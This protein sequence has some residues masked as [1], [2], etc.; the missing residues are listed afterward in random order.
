MKGILAYNISTETRLLLFIYSFNIVL[1]FLI[2]VERTKHFTNSIG[3]NEKESNL[4]EHQET[5]MKSK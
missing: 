1:L 4:K 5:F 3:L 2:F